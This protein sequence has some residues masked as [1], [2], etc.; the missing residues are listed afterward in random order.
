MKSILLLLAS[1][2]LCGVWFPSYLPVFASDIHGGGP[3]ALGMMLAS[4]GTGALLGAYALAKRSNIHGLGARTAF[5]ALA[6][7][8]C[9]I[10]F[11]NLRLLPLALVVLLCLGF[12]M[13]TL[14]VGTNTIVQTLAPDELRGRISS[15][16]TVSLLGI[17]PVGA[18]SAGFAAEWIGVPAVMTAGGMGCLLAACLM[19]LRVADISHPDL[20]SSV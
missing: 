2:S 9:L 11:A 15:V 14:N 4:V 12:S 20:E 10:L 3:I 19:G 5:G 7:S 13:V 17:G 1:A 18:L 8:I 6:F 16:Y